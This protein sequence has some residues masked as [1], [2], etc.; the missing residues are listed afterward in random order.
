MT[1]RREILKALGAA[2]LA[3]PF[4][5]LAQQPQKVRRI[6]FVGLGIPTLPGAVLVRQTLSDALLRLGYE[7]G[8]NLIVERRYAEFKPER[9]PAL[10]DELI[11]LNVELIVTVTGPATLAAMRATRTLPIVMV[12]PLPVEQGLIASHARPGGNVTG[13][14][15]WPA[16][17]LA[18]KT[19][20]VIKDAVPSAKRA[21]K[22][23]YPRKEYGPPDAK[24]A[25]KIASITGLT[26]VYIDMKRSDE[27]S[28]VLDQI[29]ASR[30]DV[31]LVS[32]D[33]FF[34]AH[35]ASIAAFAIKRKLVSISEA[36]AYTLAGGLLH[37]GTDPLAY[38]ERTASFIDRILRGAN[39]AD[40][41]AEQPTQYELV[42]NR[43]TAQAIGMTFP[44]SFMLQVTR[45]IE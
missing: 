37:Y 5:S 12:A 44:Q 33:E 10:V 14:D 8:R 42:L 26:I 23:S 3:Q 20:Q 35:F 7:E 21:V 16:P 36:P 18:G 32:G 15:T 28:G 25:R 40:L 43:K 39:P 29:A 17:E 22:L 27:L 2:T 30:A 1:S 6:G 24:A 34:N 31:L 11:R 41:P 38:T 4:A 45:V 19:F 9:Y 13:V